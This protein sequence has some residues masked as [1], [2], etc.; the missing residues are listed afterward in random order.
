MRMNPFVWPVNRQDN[1]EHITHGAAPRK[2]NAERH[3]GG[4]AAPAD[5]S[6]GHRRVQLQLS[7]AP[8]LPCSVC[9]LWTMGSS[10]RWCPRSS[11]G[12]PTPT[13][14]LQSPAPT[15]HATPQRVAAEGG[16]SRRPESWEA[17]LLLSSV[18]TKCQQDWEEGH[19]S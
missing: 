3:T 2:G 1:G 16:W 7:P 14:L 12:S 19:E 6:H 8:C 5:L 17:T 18:T 10:G 15:P 4:G 9:S 13:F 11:H